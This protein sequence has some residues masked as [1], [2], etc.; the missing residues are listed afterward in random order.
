MQKMYTNLVILVLIFCTAGPTEILARKS[1]KNYTR[2][3]A[4][5]KN[6]NSYI[7]IVWPITPLDADIQI[8][9]LL[10]QSGRI[11]H[12]QSFILSEAEVHKL[13]RIAHPHILDTDEHVRWYFPPGTLAKPARVYVILFD[14][15]EIAVEAKHK[16]RRLFK[17]QYRSIHINDTRSETKELGKFFFK[18]FKSFVSPQIVKG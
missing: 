17:L 5:L 1:N 2:I 6:S 4:Y 10:C 11:V 13:L 15:L 8:E 18:R 7:A 3:K 16:V 9:E 12:K 14:S